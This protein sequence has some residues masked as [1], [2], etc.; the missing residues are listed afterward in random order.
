MFSV[1]TFSRGKPNAFRKAFWS[2][3]RKGGI[4]E[5]INVLHFFADLLE[6]AQHDLAEHEK[7][8]WDQ[9]LIKSLDIAAN[10][11]PARILAADVLGLYGYECRE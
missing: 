2:Q 11:E 4:N 9:L 5:V 10:M 6:H 7:I 1:E 8:N 3:T